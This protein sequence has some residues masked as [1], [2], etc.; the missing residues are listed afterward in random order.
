VDCFYFAFGE[1]DVYLIVDLPDAT[2]VAAAALAVNAGGG[3]TTKTVV[4]MTAAEADV[5]AS[6]T[7][8]YRPPGS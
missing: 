1:T 8:S 5:A 3:A 7:T 4:L 2:S 6:M